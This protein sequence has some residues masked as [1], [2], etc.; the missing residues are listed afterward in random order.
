M[1]GDQSY[2]VRLLRK[3][4]S[5]LTKNGHQA[6]G[7]I[8]GKVMQRFLQAENV[9]TALE[10][11]YSVE[12]W[13][14]FAL[15]LMWY[16]EKMKGPNAGVLRSGLMDYQVEELY[17][18]LVPAKNEH[19]DSAPADRVPA[20]PVQSGDIREALHNFGRVLEELKRKS[21]EGDRFTG[22]EQALLEGALHEAATLQQAAGSR[23][24]QD[25]ERFCSAFSLFVRY[26]LERALL[27]DVRV[28]NL[29]D[30]ANLT[31]QTVMDT[32]GAEDFDSLHQ[33]I[34]LLENP[35]TLLE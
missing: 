23:G 34:E 2:V 8:L 32:V 3:V 24:N 14:Q 7:D 30:S 12:G 25:V 1:A 20:A 27:R 11:L 21:F 15:K 16:V 31:L 5:L 4:E 19:T 6:K 22:I 28:V 29:I 10:N 13:D 18:I 17:S 35:K 26:V 33:T 9:K